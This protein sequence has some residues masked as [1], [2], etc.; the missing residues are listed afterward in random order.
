[1]LLQIWILDDFSEGMSIVC[2]KSENDLQPEP[3]EG[4]HVGLKW[5]KEFKKPLQTSLVWDL[6]F[7]WIISFY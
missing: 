1:M 3:Q 6:L 7:I 5:Q 2:R 4:I